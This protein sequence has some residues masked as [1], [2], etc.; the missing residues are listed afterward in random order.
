MPAHVALT[1]V[2]VAVIDGPRER[3][4]YHPPPL[5]LLQAWWSTES[6]LHKTF[7]FVNLL[8]QKS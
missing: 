7:I 3:L 4:R 1:L 8:S 6:F 2:H 5:K